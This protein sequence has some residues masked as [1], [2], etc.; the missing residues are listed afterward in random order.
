MQTETPPRRFWRAKELYSEPGHAGRLP[1]SKPTFF[2]NLR[3]GFYPAGRL[4]SPNIR[5][6]T[7]TDVLAMEGE[8]APAESEN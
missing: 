5:V 7:E 4:I 1:I 8:P 2:K 6:W 3:D